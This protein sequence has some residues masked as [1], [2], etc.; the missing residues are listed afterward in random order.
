MPDLLG[1]PRPTQ[2]LGCL[3]E[4]A[5]TLAAAS[6]T[7][8]DACPRRAALLYPPLTALPRFERADPP[9]HVPTRCCVTALLAATAAAARVFSTSKSSRP[10]R[11]AT[12]FSSARSSSMTFSSVRVL[13]SVASRNRSS[14]RRSSKT[15]PMPP[16]AIVRRIRARVRSFGA[17]RQG[18]SEAPPAGRSDLPSGCRNPSAT[19]GNGLRRRRASGHVPWGRCVWLP[20]PPV[21]VVE[22]VPSI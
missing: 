3:Q 12:R 14:Q 20:Y 21:S 15:G 18:P 22:I 2:C 9:R 11:A 8:F 13:F 17:R 16:R 4:G 1:S 7:W 6:G 5:G 10:S 19:P